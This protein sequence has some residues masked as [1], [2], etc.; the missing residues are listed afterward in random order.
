[1]SPTAFICWQCDFCT[2]Q[3]ESSK[4]GLCIMCQTPFSKRQ[5]IAA[6]S[7]LA[8]AVSSVSATEPL[9]ICKP[10][11]HP[12]SIVLDVVGIGSGDHGCHCEVHK[13]TLPMNVL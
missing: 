13:N 10:K 5:A 9:P 1:M 8:S 12:G 2:Y 4:P 6:T 7:D 11:R 3:N